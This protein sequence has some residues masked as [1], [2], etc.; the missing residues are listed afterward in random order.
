MMPAL[1]EEIPRLE[2]KLEQA[3]ADLPDPKKSED[4]NEADRA[5]LA[6]L[7]GV[8]VEKIGRRGD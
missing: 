8:P 5:R 4:L 7:L 3:A 2:G 6:D 1:M